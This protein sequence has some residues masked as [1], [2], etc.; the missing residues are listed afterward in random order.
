MGQ[1]KNSWLRTLL[2]MVILLP[3]IGW[4]IMFSI[5]KNN[6]SGQ[7]AQQCSEECSKNGNS[8]YEFKWNILSGPVCECIQ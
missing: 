6:E 4:L 5:K 7:R 2:F 8:G 1:E 3:V